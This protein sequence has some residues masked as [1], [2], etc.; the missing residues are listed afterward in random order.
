[1]LTSPRPPLTRRRT[2]THLPNSERLAP[3]TLRAWRLE[4]K[5][6]KAER[7]SRALILA[8]LVLGRAAARLRGSGTL[9][10]L[11]SRVSP[12]PLLASLPRW[13]SSKNGDG[14]DDDSGSSSKG[15]R[16]KKKRPAAAVV[17]DDDAPLAEHVD[18]LP[19]NVLPA[20]DAD[21]VGSADEDGSLMKYS[22]SISTMPPVLVFP[23]SNRPLFPGVYQPCEVTHEGLVAALVAA[24]ASHHPFVGVFLPKLNENGEQP[25]LSIV[26]DPAQVHEVGTLAQITRLTQTPKGVQILLLGGRRVTLDRVIQ[27][28]PVMLAKVEE[29]ADEAETSPNGPSLAK[30]YSMEVMQTIKEILK[31]NP[32]FKEQ[33]QMI[34]E[35][36]EM[37][38]SGKLADFG[39]AL[40]TADA[41]DLQQ[42]P[43]RPHA[44]H[45]AR[46]A[47]AQ[48]GREGRLRRAPPPREP[49]TH[50]RGLDASGCD[51]WL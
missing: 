26:T 15:S 23:F 11:R 40:T 48:A 19:E 20:D 18:S 13:L 2:M 29:A 9:A 8:M 46:S 5:A 51:G 49:R 30:A 27:S 44:S 16:F 28:T 3:P 17:V 31:L 32:F 6:Q 24:K 7:R 12:P 34:L 39:A 25:E 37:H 10:P 4:E 21:D 38:E 41:Q 14:G 22:D 47:V 35:R 43:C 42:V 50:G 33:M 36:T 1:M 45:A